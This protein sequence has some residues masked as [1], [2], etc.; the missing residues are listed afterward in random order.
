MGESLDDMLLL[1]ARDLLVNKTI[2]NFRSLFDYIPYDIIARKMEISNSRLLDLI[3]R[4][5]NFKL[6]EIYRLAEI[7]DYD[8]IKLS[9]MI[10]RIVDE[11]WGSKLR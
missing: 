5:E 2:K 4:P 3:I 1:M 7:L 11:E 8:P 10:G 9:Q 6:S